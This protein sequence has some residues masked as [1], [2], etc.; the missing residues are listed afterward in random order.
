MLQRILK[1]GTN[2][3]CRLT[4]LILAMFFVPTL[5]QRSYKN[6]FSIHVDSKSRATDSFLGAQPSTAPTTDAN[7]IRVMKIVPSYDFI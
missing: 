4:L 7:R 2:N 3:V 1:A 6:Q 5:S